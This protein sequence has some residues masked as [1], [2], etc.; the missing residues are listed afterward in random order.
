MCI[1][2]QE[3]EE[4]EDGDEELGLLS[5]ARKTPTPERSSDG[6]ARGNASGSEKGSGK[7]H[8]TGPKKI[9]FS[10][11]NASVGKEPKESKDSEQKS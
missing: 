11:G 4:D 6:T 2:V 9:L 1:D 7:G 10:F 3:R 8:A 5:R